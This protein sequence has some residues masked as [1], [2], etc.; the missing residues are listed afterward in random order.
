V[1]LQLPQQQAAAAAALAVDLP[2]GVF[3]QQLETNPVD[4]TKP[5]V[6]VF[7]FGS[8]PLNCVSVAVR[9][10]GRELRVP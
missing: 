6:V 3:S 10:E 8:D 1:K 9:F 2:G 7:V 5:D 4:E